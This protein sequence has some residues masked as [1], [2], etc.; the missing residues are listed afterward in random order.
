MQ[1]Y[2]NAVTAEEL[3]ADG[4]AYI[5]GG[6]SRKRLESYVVQLKI[7]VVHFMLMVEEKWRLAKDIYSTYDKERMKQ[8]VWKGEKEQTIRMIREEMLS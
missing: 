7:H 2:E 4:V 1:L 8:H 6:M 3:S 5:C